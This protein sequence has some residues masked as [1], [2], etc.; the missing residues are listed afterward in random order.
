MKWVVKKV[1]V[2]LKHNTVI[3]TG[4]FAK[5]DTMEV[6]AVYTEC[7]SWLDGKKSS[8]IKT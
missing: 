1:K 4:I 6:N 8:R 7:I 2:I 3:L 5:N